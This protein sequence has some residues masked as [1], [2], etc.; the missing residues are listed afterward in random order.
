M[1]THALIVR[2]HSESKSVISSTP[3]ILIRVIMRDCRTFPLQFHILAA[4][5]NCTLSKANSVLCQFSIA[6]HMMVFSV[7]APV[8]TSC[9][10]RNCVHVPSCLHLRTDVAQSSSRRNH[11]NASTKQPSHTGERRKSGDGGSEVKVGRVD[12]KRMTKGV[13]YSR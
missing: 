8:R 4:I 12:S 10:C 7:L 1:S 5:S 2:S 9:C 3:I 11:H 6:S 13:G